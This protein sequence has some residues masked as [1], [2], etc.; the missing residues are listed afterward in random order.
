MCMPQITTKNLRQDLL[1]TLIKCIV[2]KVKSESAV[3]FFLP[4]E[5]K[6]GILSSHF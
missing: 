2:L 6:K 4:E 1:Q 3:L 5:K